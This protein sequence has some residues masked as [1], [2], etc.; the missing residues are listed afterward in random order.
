M[1]FFLRISVALLSF[2]SPLKLFQVHQLQLTSPPPSCITDLFTLQARPKY[3][4][5][6]ELSFI[7]SPW[8]TRRL[9]LLSNY[10]LISVLVEICVQSLCYTTCRCLGQDQKQKRSHW[11]TNTL[12]MYFL[13]LQ[14]VRCSRFY[15]FSSNF[16]TFNCPVEYTD[17]FS[18]EDLKKQRVSWI[19]H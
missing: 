14:R 16:N 1:W 17:F 11:E 8:T 13:P 18:S 15:K 4:F 7:F 2:P 5:S 10:C 12:A 6:F 3:L 19:W 9:L